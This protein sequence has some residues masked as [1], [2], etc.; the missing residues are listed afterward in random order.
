MIKKI[1]IL[2]TTFLFTFFAVIY[3]NSLSD[4]QTKITTPEQ[5]AFA[6]ACQYSGYDCYGV[7]LPIVIYTRSLYRG[8]NGASFGNN[9]IAV[10]WVLDPR[11]SK[12]A[13]GVLIHEMVHYLQSRILEPIQ[14]T[15]PG[16]M[17]WCMMEEQAFNVENAWLEHM[18]VDPESRKRW[19]TIYNCYQSPSLEERQRI[20]EEA[21]KTEFEIIIEAEVEPPL[22]TPE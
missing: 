15:V 7:E 3:I 21:T 4:N 12:N 19:A 18:G 17:Y 1:A 5:Y 10:D 2:L 13:M 14:V 16:N 6:M 8:Y 9:V 11:N 20:V 22:G